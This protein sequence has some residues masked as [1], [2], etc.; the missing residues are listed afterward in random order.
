[1]RTIQ[2]LLREGDPIR[3]ES[4]WTNEA[5][6]AVRTLVVNAPLPAARHETGRWLASGVA[7]AALAFVFVAAVGLLRSRPVAAATI[8][9]AVRLAE[10]APAPGL[11]EATVEGS[12]RTIYLHPET[13][14]GNGDLAKA[15]VIEGAAGFG[16]AV[17]LSDDG[18]ARMYRATSSHINRPLAIL[19]DGVVVTAPTVR[20][21]IAAS[22]VLDGDYTRAEA[23][24]IA[25]GIQPR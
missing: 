17:T 24:R 22:A 3:H 2:E 9:F 13:I 18:A 7:L 14:V 1:M 4:R 5:R 20:G 11:E 21:P 19:L 12:D 6:L 8:D 10:D 25:L 15:Q 23:E 16:V